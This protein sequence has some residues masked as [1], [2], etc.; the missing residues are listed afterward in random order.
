MSTGLKRIGWVGTGR[1]GHAM[2]RRLLL[3]GH[4]V[5]VWN[6]TRAKAEDLVEDGAVLVEGVR[7]LAD[8]DIVF[9]MVAADAD[10][11]AVLLGEGGLLRQDRAPG[12][13]VDSST[14][15]PETSVQVRRACEERGTAFL[16]C[17]VSGN[18]RVVAAGKLSI[19]ASGP[20]DGFDLVEPLLLDIAPSV[21]YVGDGD[22]ARLVKIAH[23]VFLGVV[24]QSLAEITVLAERGGVS[25]ADFLDFLN[26]SVLGSVFTRYK[27]PAFVNLDMTATFTTRLLRKDLDL[28]LD[29][30]RDLE[31]PLPLTGAAQALVQ[32]AIGAGH[33][34]SDFAALLLEVARGAGVALEPEGVDVDDGL[35]D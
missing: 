24:T 13:L 4:D 9:T 12:C 8:R 32:T 35:T 18:A 27:S 21:T 16:A 15:S 6:R 20:R 10:L 28:G 22:Q 5:H 14:V 7:D 34:D 19:A 33:G 3:V 17:P 23:N 1:M 25:R 11:T 31:V 29:L 30:G 2:V 26:Q